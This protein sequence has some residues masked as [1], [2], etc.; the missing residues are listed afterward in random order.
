MSKPKL[1]APNVSAAKNL[2]RQPLLAIR[3]CDCS[4]AK[5]RRILPKPNTADFE[6]L[7][8]AASQADASRLSRLQA[9]AFQS[10]REDWGKKQG[11]AD[12]NLERK[13]QRLVSWFAA[14][15]SQAR[16]SRVLWLT[17]VAILGAFIEVAASSIVFAVAI[18]VLVA[19]VAVVIFFRRPSHSGRPDIAELLDEPV[20][21][22]SAAG[23][24]E[25]LSPA[26]G[27]G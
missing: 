7:I 23:L 21:A 15:P 1:T 27:V 8:A 11:D 4:E 25:S 2:P 17:V 6:A 13:L 18:A 10:M 20:T 5:A 12:P 26:K 19:I 24:I 9:D 14:E 22:A 16:D 3:R